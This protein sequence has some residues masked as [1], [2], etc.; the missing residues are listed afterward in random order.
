M[1]KEEITQ[2]E[3]DFQ[4]TLEEKREKLRQLR[5]SLPSGKVKNTSEIRKIKKEIARIMTKISQQKK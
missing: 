1:Q 5:F 4:R 3:K 2:K